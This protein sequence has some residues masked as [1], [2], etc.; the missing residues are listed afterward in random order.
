MHVFSENRTQFLQPSKCRC[1]TCQKL[2]QFV[3]KWHKIGDFVG[4]FLFL[5][6]L[7]FL[8]LELLNQCVILVPCWRS[9]F[10]GVLGVPFLA[11]RIACRM[12]SNWRSFYTQ[13][14]YRGWVLMYSRAL[15]GYGIGFDRVKGIVL[16]FQGS[17]CF[18]TIWSEILIRKSW[19]NYLNRIFR[20]NSGYGSEIP[21]RMNSRYTVK[22]LSICSS[23]SAS[24]A[25]TTWPSSRPLTRVAA[26]IGN[27]HKY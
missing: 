10:S 26:G 2:G 1:R 17:E 12:T 4:K 19:M 11:V 21:Q 8:L 24:S 7:R 23:D 6:H 15:Y 18:P 14:C 20:E 3:I 16:G 27:T 22:L 13:S 9:S 25:V 5:C